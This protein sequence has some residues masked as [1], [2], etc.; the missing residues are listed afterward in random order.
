MVALL[1]LSSSLAAKGASRPF[2]KPLSSSVTVGLASVVSAAETRMAAEPHNSA[3]DKVMLRNRFKLFTGNPPFPFLGVAF[4]FT[5]GHAA[6]G[7]F[8]R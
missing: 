7:G 5:A 2:S 1:P 3:A 6:S 8:A 4:Y